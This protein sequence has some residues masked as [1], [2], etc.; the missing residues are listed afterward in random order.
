[1]LKSDIENRNDIL[2]AFLGEDPAVTSTSDW[3]AAAEANAWAHEEDF[4]FDD[5]LGDLNEM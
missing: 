4:P 3:I 5:Y 2:A 1:M